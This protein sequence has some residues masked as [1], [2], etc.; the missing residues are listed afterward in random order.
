MGVELAVVA[1]VVGVWDGGVGVWFLLLDVG[2][3]V[4]VAVACRVGVGGFE[5]GME[6]EGCGRAPGVEGLEEMG[7]LERVL[8]ARSMAVGVE[9]VERDGGLAWWKE[10]ELSRAV[11]WT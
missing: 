6:F 10:R 11:C 3:L 5:C 1:V 8:R 9:V 2:G 4:V 7:M